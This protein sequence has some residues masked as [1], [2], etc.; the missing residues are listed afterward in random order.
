MTDPESVFV[1]ALASFK[2]RS[3]YSNIVNDRSAVYYTTSIS[4]IDP[5]VNISAVKIN[6][7]SEYS[8]VIVDMADPV[9]AKEESSILPTFRQ[10]FFTKTS[11]LL[12][13]LRLTVFLAFFVPLGA[14]LFL[15]NAAVQS[16]RSQQRIRLHV[17][18]KAGVGPRAYHIPLM[19][20]NVQ[21]T[22]EDMFENINNRQEQ[23]YLP[24]GS[25]EMAHPD[26]PLLSSFKSTA[27]AD[28]SEPSW[29]MQQRLGFRPL[30]LAPA[31]F[32]MIQALDDV[33]WKKYPVHFHNVTH[34]H[35]AII[36]RTNRPIF[37]EGRLVVKHWLA[38]FE[39]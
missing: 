36:V 2:H 7:L 16:V 6:Y 10:R 20:G 37:D 25:E 18:G 38:N 39:I 19:V 35:A 21:R 22:A 29:K 27:A 30:A 28:A 33:G 3:L 1:R 32:A 4:P 14:T 8:P 12:T 15:L 5:F 24:A 23:E 17:E 34:S 9:S 13:Q 26:S 11:N 31:Q